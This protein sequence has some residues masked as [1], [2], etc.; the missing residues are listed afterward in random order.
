MLE[1]GTQDIAQMLGMMDPWYE[2]NVLSLLSLSSDVLF[3]VTC[4]SFVC[5]RASHSES[6]EPL[7]EQQLLAHCEVYWTNICTVPW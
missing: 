5:S 1:D 2:R 4:G 7:T 3:Q 6:G